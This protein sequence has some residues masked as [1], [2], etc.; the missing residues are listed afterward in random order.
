MLTRSHTDPLDEAFDML[1]HAHRR[2]MLLALYTAE[3]Q[4]ALPVEELLP[5][6]ASRGTFL[7]ELHH[8]HCPKLA[9]AGYIEWDRSNHAIRKGAQFG[10]IEPLIALLFEHRDRL[11]PGAL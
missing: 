7:T 8:C 3:A 10:T 11:P 6:E 9:N 5:A 1:C 2:R 4:A